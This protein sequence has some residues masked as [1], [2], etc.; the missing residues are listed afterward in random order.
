M[1]SS[2]QYINTKLIGLTHN[3]NFDNC[4]RR[5]LQNG[6]ICL[7]STRTSYPNWFLKI[8]LC[9][10]C[11][12]RSIKNESIHTISYKLYQYMP[13]SI[14]VLLLIQCVLILLHCRPSNVFSGFSVGAMVKIIFRL[15]HRRSNFL[16]FVHILLA[17]DG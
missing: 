15:K 6:L 8:P 14:L 1:W 2:N 7:L 9:W 3:N 10:H 13:R 5:F 17:R 12:T 4:S 16:Q 11:T